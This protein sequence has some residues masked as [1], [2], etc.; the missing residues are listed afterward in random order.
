MQRGGELAFDLIEVVPDPV[1]LRFACADLPLD[2]G[3][4]VGSLRYWAKADL[5]TP[6]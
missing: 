3:K 4:C 5:S 6:F 1:E 2:I